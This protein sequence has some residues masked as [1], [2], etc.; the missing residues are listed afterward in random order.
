MLAKESSMNKSNFSYIFI[1]E[2]NSFFDRDTR[3]LHFNI[4]CLIRITIVH[5]VLK[6]RCIVQESLLEISLHYLLVSQNLISLRTL[7]VERFILHFNL[8]SMFLS[9]DPNFNY[10]IANS[11]ERFHYFRRK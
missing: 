5:N 3:I 1:H 10:L 2:W 8:F 7:S 6:V 9:Q 11:A 4:Q